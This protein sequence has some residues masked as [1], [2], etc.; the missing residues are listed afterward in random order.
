MVQEN[1]KQKVTQKDKNR[2]RL[3]EYLSEPENSWP[4]RC[5]YAETILGYKDHKQIYR[6]FTPAQIGDIE[7]EAME[8]RKKRSARQRSVLYKV[9]YTE[10]V[11]GNITALKEFLD[12]TEGKVPDKKQH[13]G[14][15]N[16][17]IRWAE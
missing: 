17:N 14:D 6:N 8:N 1:H 13:S 15:M 7:A 5:E 2:I 4:P 10:S 16:L 9:L 3:V 12:R 11:Q